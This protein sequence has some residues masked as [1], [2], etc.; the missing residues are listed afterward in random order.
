VNVCVW[1]VRCV[2]GGEESEKRGLGR[3]TDKQDIYWEEMKK[4][5]E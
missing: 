1:G 3:E 2:R 5:E 4:L